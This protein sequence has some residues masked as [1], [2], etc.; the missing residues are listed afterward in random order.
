[1]CA[2]SNEKLQ[3]TVTKSV[4]CSNSDEIMNALKSGASIKINLTGSD[5][6]I[7]QPLPIKAHTEFY[8]TAKQA[9][10]FRFNNAFAL[11]HV[12]GG[13]TLKLSGLNFNFSKAD[14][15]KADF[16]STDSAGSSDHSNIIIERCEFNKMNNPGFAF[17]ALFKIYH[18]RQHYYQ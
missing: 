18:D 4:N 7:N 1:M 11:F 10:Y 3:T 6:L 17:F 13:G 12:K 14:I 8:S 15:I 5:Y 16:I 9:I 2:E